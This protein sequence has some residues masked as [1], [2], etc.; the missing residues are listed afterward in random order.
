M[1]RAKV[2]ENA[3]WCGRPGCKYPNAFGVLHFTEEGAPWAVRLTSTRWRRAGHQ[4]GLERFAMVGRTGRI[5][6]KRADGTTRRSWHRAMRAELPAIL[7]CPS[8]DA[9]QAIGLT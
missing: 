6:A 9:V 5:V 1:I 4:D 8:C 7:V 3:V 2:V